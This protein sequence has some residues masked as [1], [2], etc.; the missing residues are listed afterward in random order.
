MTASTVMTYLL[1]FSSGLA[2][3]WGAITGIFYLT[4]ANLLAA[5]DRPGVVNLAGSVD[6]IKDLAGPLVND[7]S[8]KRKQ[9]VR[10]MKILFGILA[11]NFFIL[12]QLMMELKL[13]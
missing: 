3:L 5:L 9:L 1:F 11:G 12:I 4:L 13:L 2:L 6:Q 8:L 10:A 7:I